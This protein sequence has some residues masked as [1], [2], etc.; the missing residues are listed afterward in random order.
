MITVHNANWVP[1]RKTEISRAFRK[2][3]NGRALFLDKDTGE[4]YELEQW[5]C[6]SDIR[7]PLRLANS[8]IDTPSH[9][10]LKHYCG[11]GH[12]AR[13]RDFKPSRINIFARDKGMCQYCGK[14][15]SLKKGSFTVDHI[16][17]T[18]K[19]GR[20][21]WA[22]LVTACHDCNLKKGSRDLHETGMKL[23]GPPKKPSQESIMSTLRKM[24]MMIMEDL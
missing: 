19:G 20:N 22:N 17:P 7:K 15:M 5:V 14:E 21:D 12:G 10:L 1:I 11:N 9:I 6:K 16:V 23:L 3:I 24:R 8:V 2:V 4:T 13:V 18:S